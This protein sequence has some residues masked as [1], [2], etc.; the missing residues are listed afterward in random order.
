[1]FTFFFFSPDGCVDWLIQHL[2]GSEV[3]TQYIGHVQRSAS[4]FLIYVNVSLCVIVNENLH[5]VLINVS[6]DFD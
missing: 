1:M 2:V 4:I 5:L 6:F 3:A